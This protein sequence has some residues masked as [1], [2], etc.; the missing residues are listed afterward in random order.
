MRGGTLELGERLLAVAGH[1]GRPPFGT[2]RYRL[3]WMAAVDNFVPEIVPGSAARSKP[4]DHKA[5]R[6]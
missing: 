3:L 4:L 1:D 2:Q 6:R 5:T